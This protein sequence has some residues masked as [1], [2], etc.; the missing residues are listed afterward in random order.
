VR[1]FPEMTE[2]TALLRKDLL[3]LGVRP[4]GL[5]LVHSSF[6]SLQRGG[7][8]GG[9]EIVIQ[10]LLETLG[11]DGTLLMPALTFARVTPENPVFDIRNTPSCVGI[12]PEAFRIRPGTLR[13][14]HPT[15][16]VCATGPLAAGLIEAHATDTTPCGPHSPFRANAERGGQILFLGCGL[17]SNTTMHAVEEMIVPPYLYDTPFEYQLLLADGS[18]RQKIYT[19]HNFRGWRQR[20]DRVAEILRPPAMSHATVAGARSILLDSSAL[21]DTTLAELWKDPLCFVDRLPNPLGE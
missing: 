17:E 19:P 8:A 5:L 18:E 1:F 2:F 3:S 10:G 9:P 16:S 7:E 12:I 13:S 6:R 11:P 21:W 20:Y 14:L 15:H 4:G